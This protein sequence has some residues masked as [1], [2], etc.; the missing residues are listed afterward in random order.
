MLKVIFFKEKSLLTKFDRLDF[1]FFFATFIWWN[2][3]KLAIFLLKKFNLWQIYSAIFGGGDLFLNFNLLVWQIYSIILLYSKFIFAI[4]FCNFNS[5]QIILVILLMANLF[6]NFYLW[7][8]SVIFIYGSFN[9]ILIWK[10]FERLIMSIY[11]NSWQFMP[12][13]VNYSLKNNK[14]WHS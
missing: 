2:I 1:F 6:C 7:F 4:L 13:Y 12:I 3:L 11:G 10:T 8:G 5:W 9:L 14:L